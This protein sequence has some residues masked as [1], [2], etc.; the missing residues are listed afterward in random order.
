MADLDSLN[1]YFQAEDDRL[2]AHFT[3]PAMPVCFIMEMG[4]SGSTV[5]IQALASSLRQGYVGRVLAKHWLA[6]YMGALMEK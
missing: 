5:L 6:P 2:T 4:R 1:A 3:E